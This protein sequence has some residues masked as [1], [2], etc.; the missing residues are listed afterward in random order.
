MNSTEAEEAP[1][2]AAEKVSPRAA[3]STG[4]ITGRPLIPVFS[5]VALV[6]ALSFYGMS[7]RSPSPPLRLLQILLDNL[8]LTLPVL[9]VILSTI[10]GVR[11][12][13]KGDGWLRLPTS[14]ALGLVSF[15]IWYQVTAQNT[16]DPVIR[17]SS[18]KYLMKDYGV[19]LLVVS[20]IWATICTVAKVLSETTAKEKRHFLWY[21]TQALLLSVSFVALGT[22]FFLFESGDDLATRL[23]L[24]PK[25]RFYS[26]SVAFIDPALAKWVGVEPGE[27]VRSYTFKQFRAVTAE[28]ARENALKEFKTLPAAKQFVPPKERPRE[29]PLQVEI[30][31]TWVV[32]EREPGIPLAQQLAPNAIKP[33]T[34][35]P[36]PALGTGTVRKPQ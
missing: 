9:S 22:P 13:L 4:W 28:D 29:N 25:E 36:R 30:R 35:A 26:V 15:S 12:L 10:V 8:P 24:E 7:S 31:D 23:K 32:V 21:S 17:I 14:L 19:L 20:F 34:A 2:E 33:S 3:L 6:A 5:L 27:I 11:E 1:A 18:D 16:A